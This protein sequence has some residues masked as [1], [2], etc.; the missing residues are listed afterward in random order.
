[1]GSTIQALPVLSVSSER[2]EARRIEDEYF[3]LT[4]LFCGH[5]I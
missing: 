1:M 4:G 2:V 5:R 3:F